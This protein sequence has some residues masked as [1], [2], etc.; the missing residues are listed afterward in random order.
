MGDISKNFNRK[1]FGCKCNYPE[2]VDI[3]VDLELVE[4]LEDVRE[5]F[6]GKP[7]KINCSY[8]CVIHNRD[9]GG[10]ANSQHLLGTAADIV[11]KGVHPHK[12]YEYFNTKYPNKYGVGKYN[13]FTHIDVRKRKARW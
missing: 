12:V 3:A 4:V 9:V 13:T 2:C 11:I 1:E 6:G 10:A 7:V 5:H 8:R